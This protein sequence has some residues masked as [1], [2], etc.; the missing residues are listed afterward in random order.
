MNLHDHDDDH[1][2]RTA[3]LATDQLNGD[4]REQLVSAMFLAIQYWQQATFKSKL[5]LAMES[6]IW[7]AN[8]DGSTLVTRTLDKYLRLSTLPKRPHTEEVFRT[9]HYVLNHC[10][11]HSALREQLESLTDKLIVAHHQLSL[12]S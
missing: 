5:D 3:S 12:L 6:G 9:L 4:F 1:D 10:D 8:Q 2:F 11:N 7:T